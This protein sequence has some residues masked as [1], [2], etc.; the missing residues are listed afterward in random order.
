MVEEVPAGNAL[1]TETLVRAALLLVHVHHRELSMN[2]AHTPLLLKLQALLRT[3]IAREKQDLGFNCAAMGFALEDFA[4]KKK[5]MRFFGLEHTK[6]IE[7]GAKND[8]SVTEKV[9]ADGA[10]DM[11]QVEQAKKEASMDRVKPS[12]VAKRRKLAS[13]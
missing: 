9:L 10:R 13:K 12:R 2:A 7:N 6:I 11:Q 1:F 8:L 3:K 5:G 4:Q